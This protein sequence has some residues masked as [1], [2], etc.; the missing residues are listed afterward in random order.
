MFCSYYQMIWNF[1]EIEAIL[2][3][4]T[5]CLQSLC[6]LRNLHFNSSILVTIDCKGRN[7][8]SGSVL[9]LNNTSKVSSLHLFWSNLEFIYRMVVWTLSIIWNLWL[10]ISF[11][12]Q[13]NLTQEIDVFRSKIRA[14][15]VFLEHSWSILGAFLER[16]DLRWV[17]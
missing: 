1:F 7:W 9:E 11:E 12:F 17:I 10:W 2:V 5:K 6:N 13:S 15:G 8:S 14:I 16:F 4:T 3:S